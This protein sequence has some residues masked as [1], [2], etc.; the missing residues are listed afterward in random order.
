[1][2]IMK[3]YNM[4]NKV[5]TMRIELDKPLS[6]KSLR[7]SLKMLPKDVKK[8]KVICGSGIL[9]IDRIVSDN[10]TLFLCTDSQ[11]TIDFL[12]KIKKNDTDKIHWINTVTCNND[13]NKEWEKYRKQHGLPPNYI[14]DCPG[15]GDTITCQSK[16][17][18]NNE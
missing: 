15:F 9:D 11:Q 6:R 4:L 18:D 16:D 10:D 5:M 3:L 14:G 8:I 1:M 12:K 2:L 7:Q 17:D 13:W